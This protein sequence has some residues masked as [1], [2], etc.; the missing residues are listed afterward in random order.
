MKAHGINFAIIISVSLFMFSGNGFAQ[1]TWLN[2]PA[3]EM[4]KSVF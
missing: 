3:E 1:P 4:Q 2:G